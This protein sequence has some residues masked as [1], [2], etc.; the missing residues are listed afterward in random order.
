MSA[1]TR[2][3]SAVLLARAVIFNPERRVTCKL[4]VIYYPMRFPCHIDEVL[5][6]S[7]SE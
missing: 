5:G 7:P 1:L 2:L 4:G 3:H 6:L